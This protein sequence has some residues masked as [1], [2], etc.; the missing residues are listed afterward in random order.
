MAPKRGQGLF[1]DAKLTFCDRARALASRAPQGRSETFFLKKAR[2][3]GTF[4]KGCIGLFKTD[5][6]SMRNPTTRATFENRFR[7]IGIIAGSGPEAGVDLW[8]K[9]LLAARAVVGKKYEGDP[10]APLVRIISDP[11]LGLQINDRTGQIVRQHL[12]DCLSEVSS[13]SYVFTVACNA[14]QAQA[15][16]LLPPSNQDRFITFDKAVDAELESLDAREFFL[17]GSSEVMSLSHH[18]I[19]ASLKNKYRIQTPE[20]WPMV[21]Q[22]IADIKLSGGKEASLPARLERLISD[23]GSL[24]VVLACTDFPLVPVASSNHIVI[25]ATLTLASLLVE[26]A[27]RLGGEEGMRHELPLEMH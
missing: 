12:C 9:V 23:A 26:R 7:P 27:A 24:P 15:L 22:L 13:S 20:D 11:A 25:D 17:A 5:A 6:L 16:R 2:L 10:S 18:S 8:S 21:D 3:A 19:Y 4:T 14:L 1:S